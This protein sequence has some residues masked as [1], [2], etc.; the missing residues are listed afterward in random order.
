M[1]RRRGLGGTRR[2]RRPGRGVT[3]GQINAPDREGFQAA[4]VDE[5]KGGRRPPPQPAAFYPGSGQVALPD[6]SN[7]GG[8][9]EQ[10]PAC[11]VRVRTE[12]SGTVHPPRG[13]GAGTGVGRSLVSGLRG[14]V[15]ATSQ[16]RAGS[17]KLT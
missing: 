10:F 6:P 8:Y 1:G 7:N 2:G 11:S 9:R 17:G 12:E 4:L 14:P 3:V 16:L 15:K 13:R 5:T